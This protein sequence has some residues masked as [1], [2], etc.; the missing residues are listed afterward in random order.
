MCDIPPP[1]PA[2]PALPLIELVRGEF[3][4]SRNIICSDDPVVLFIVRDDSQQQHR[5]AGGV[6]HGFMTRPR[7]YRFSS[8]AGVNAATPGCCGTIAKV[9][10]ISWDST[11]AGDV[12]LS[13]RSVFFWGGGHS[14]LLELEDLPS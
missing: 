10:R 1:T 4:Q 13:R 12:R 11:V 7:E 14:V 2:A 5:P 8:Q 9:V 6:Y 3:S